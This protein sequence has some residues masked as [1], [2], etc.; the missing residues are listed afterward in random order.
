MIH[1][2]RNYNPHLRQL[3]H[4]GYKVAAQLGDRFTAA[5][6]KHA[7]IIAENVTTNTFDRH[8]RRIFLDAD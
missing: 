5:L 2:I 1:P 7:A 8:L 6:K 4:V 3:L